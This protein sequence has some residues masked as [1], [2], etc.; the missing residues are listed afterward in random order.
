MWP[1]MSSGVFLFRRTLLV[2]A[3]PRR[4]GLCVGSLESD[5]LGALLEGNPKLEQ[6]HNDGAE[7]LEEGI[8]VRSVLLHVGLEDLVLGKGN[9]GGQHH[10]GLA[11]VLELLGAVPLA[12]CPLLAQ[13]QCKVVVGEDGGREGPGTLK[14]RSV[15]VASA[16]SVSAGE[17]DDLLVIEAHAVED[18]TEVAAALGS[19]GKPAVRSAGSDVS[20]GTARSPWDDRALHLLNGGDTTESPQVGVSNPRELLCARCD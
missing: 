15:G 3:S 18:V 16:K 1:S 10:Q 17:G 8:V 6:L 4:H 13:E 19:I 9:I 11:L 5:P 2:V 12:C 14:S 7:V 20:I